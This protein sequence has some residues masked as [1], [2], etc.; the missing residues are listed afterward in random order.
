MRSGHNVVQGSEREHTLLNVFE[1]FLQGFIIE[2]APV[3]EELVKDGR[4]INSEAL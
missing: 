4:T 2:V 3:I 1:F